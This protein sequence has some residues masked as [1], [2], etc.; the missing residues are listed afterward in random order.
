MQRSE[1]Y[2]RLKGLASEIRSRYNLTSPRVLRSDLRRI[3]RDQGITIDLWPHKL[4][5]LRG[6]YIN[7]EYGA[8]VMLA[9]G[10]PEDPMVFTMAHELKHHLTDSDHSISYCDSSNQREPIEIGA[11]VFA[12][13]LIYPEQM[14]A[15]DLEQFGA[16]SG[17]CSSEMLVRLKHTTRTT[18]SY[19]GLVKRA[20]FMGF[21]TSSDQYRGVKWKRLEEQIFGVPVYK[22][23]LA[24]NARLARG[25]F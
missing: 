12:A 16:R 6:V 4:A 15:S 10:L 17:H 21:A 19:A 25:S 23:L 14:F 22:Q 20:L 13:E 3:Y 1:Y 11:E 9:K 7:D 5:N 18:M 8:T 2:N 24:R